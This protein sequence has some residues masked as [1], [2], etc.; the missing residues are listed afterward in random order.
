M[1]WEGWW[2]MKARTRIHGGTEVISDL[3]LLLVICLPEQQPFGLSWIKAKD[4]SGIWNVLCTLVH[5]G[6]QTL[7]PKIEYKN[8]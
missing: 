8:L 7:D 1:A 6:T 4:L 3:P 5:S 2:R